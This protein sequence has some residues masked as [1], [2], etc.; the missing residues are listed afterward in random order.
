MPFLDDVDSPE[1]LLEWQ[2]PGSPY[3]R[4]RAEAPPTTSYA[5]MR[6]ACPLVTLR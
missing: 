5:I 4:Q 2:H 6:R 3:G 1:V